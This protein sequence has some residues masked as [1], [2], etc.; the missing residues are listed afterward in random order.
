[1]N[2]QYAVQI[3]SSKKGESGIYRHPLSEK[4]LMSAPEGMNSLKEL[5]LTSKKRYGPKNYIGTKQADGTF[6]WLSY[7]EATDQAIALGAALISKN[8]VPL[9][10][11]HNMELKFMGVYSKNRGEYLIADMA[12]VLYGI[13]SVPIYDTLGPDAMDFIMDQTKMSIIVLSK[14]NVQKMIQHG[15]FGYVKTLITF[16]EITDEKTLKELA[17]KKVTCLSFRDLITYGK[18]QRVEFANPN[19]NTIYIVSYTSGTTGNPKGA[20]MTHG[21]FLSVIMAA[22]YG[23][24]F[25][26]DDVYLSYLPM[27]HVFERLLMVTLIY[28]GCAIGYFGGDPLKLK[29]DLATLKPTIIISVPRVLNKFYDAFQSNIAT[30]TGCKKW[31]VDKAIDAKLGNIKSSNTVRH[32]CYDRLVFKKMKEALGGRLRWIVTGSAP[33]TKE[34]LDFLKIALCIPVMEGYGQTESTGASFVMRNTDH[35]GSGC[36]GGPTVNTEFKIADIP[37]MNYTSK[38]LDENGKPIPRGEM[39]IRGPAVFAGYYNDIEK[40]K[41]A[42]D[43]EGWL[44]T[45]DVVLLQENGSIKIIDRKKNIFKLS[46]GEYVAPEKL[47]TVFKTSSSIAEIFVH[48]DS[49]QS[50]LVAI[51][52]PKLDVLKRWADAH[53]I[54]CSDDELL[55]NKEIKML[56]L[57]EL[58]E[59]GQ[60]KKFTSFEL[61]KNLYLEKNSFAT[62]DL[63][64]TTFKMK[65]NEGKIAY[66]K[67]IADLYK[68]GPVI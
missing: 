33:A 36:I 37:E 59:D 38:D 4:D 11:D 58:K 9:N 34:V 53:Q 15:N 3:R 26:P 18:D 2:T 45:G 14:E 65:R 24:D 13:T 61:I 55:R 8:M 1:M 57:K 29:D 56:V 64:T 60:K 49:Y 67:I 44:H 48:G 41:E 62:K 46:Q 63:L 32:C 27:A 16:E 30:L 47:E 20:L 17:S 19:I 28:H 40:T 31:L 50:F 7:D 10:K 43:E 54:N 22:T 66:Q 5:V 25:T 35:V 52:V 6:T 23:M 68:E 39:C 21:N 12:A 51:V 42:L